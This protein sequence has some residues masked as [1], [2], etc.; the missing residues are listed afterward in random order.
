VPLKIAAKVSRDDEE[1]F[2]SE[3]EP[4]FESPYVEFLGEIAQRE[5]GAFL[6]EAAALLSPIEWPE[7]FGLTMIEALACGTP[8]IAHHQGSVP[9]V[10]RHGITGFIA[11]GLDEA[12]QAVE[13][14]GLISREECRAQFEQRFTARRMMEDYVEVYE[15]LLHEARPSITSLS[16]VALE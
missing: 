3:I 1:Y 7:P 2:R 9:E 8:V 6:G 13:N 15:G 11:E 5:K 10:L 4:L 16:A 12:V 14:L